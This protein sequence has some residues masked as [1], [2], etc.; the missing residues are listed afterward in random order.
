MNYQDHDYERA[1]KFLSGNMT[2]EE[3]QLF[4]Q[5]L[6]AKTEHQDFLAETMEV[7]EI[8]KLAENTQDHQA[9]WEK[10]NAHLEKKPT[11]VRRF[12]WRWAAAAAMIP[13]IA[14]SY[15]M[16]QI[17]NNSAII[18]W[19][20][21][22]TDENEQKELRLP[23]GSSISL[24]ENSQIRYPKDFKKR[25]VELKGEAFF[26]VA[27]RNGDPFEIQTNS[28]KTT[29]LGTSFNIRAY[30]EEKEME[31]HVFSGKVAVVNAKDSILL[32]PGEMAETIQ[33]ESHVIK[34]QKKEVKNAT[35]WKTKKLSFN[36]LKFKE[37]FKDLEH[38]FDIEIDIRNKDL[39]DCHFTGNYKDPQL[40]EILKVF[41]FSMDFKIEKTDNHYRID[42]QC[43]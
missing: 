19:E 25:E 18:E 3:E 9:D 17:S 20:L 6:D 4:L 36:N 28:I 27:K 37:V 41:E 29:V 23:D 15:W 5:W 2:E 31:V 35:A 12:F 24:N 43:N 26:D 34:K 38:Y 42:G 7:W 21:V 11:K 33:K 13:L 32:L 8:S 16:I 1:A 30:E 14:L 39:L 40:E 22:Q 10:I